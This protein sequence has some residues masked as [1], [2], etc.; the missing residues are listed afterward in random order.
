MTTVDVDP[1]MSAGKTGAQSIRTKRAP[2]F[3]MW[4]TLVKTFSYR[5]DPATFGGQSRLLRTTAKSLFIMALYTAPTYFIN[6]Y[7]NREDFMKYVGNGDPR[8]AKCPSYSMG[9]LDERR[10]PYIHLYLVDT[11]PWRLFLP[12]YDQIP[13]CTSTVNDNPDD[14]QSW[15]AF[16][17]DSPGHILKGHRGD[18]SQGLNIWTFFA[19]D[20]EYQSFAA[21]YVRTTLQGYVC[22]VFSFLIAVCRFTKTKITNSIKRWGSGA[23]HDYIYSWWFMKNDEKLECLDQR[24]RRI[25]GRFLS[26][27]LYVLLFEFF[28]FFFFFF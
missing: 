25:A 11:D 27:G 17:T 5:A 20:E 28:F 3:S 13:Y 24:N 19:R 6:V 9:N 18:V 1:S 22:V 21:Y 26:H 2:Q 7:G 16:G 23:Y 14:E 8:W 10:L 12:A 15:K 4:R